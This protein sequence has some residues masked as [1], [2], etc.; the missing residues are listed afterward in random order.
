[1]FKWK[2]LLIL[3]VLFFM[4]V[5]CQNGEENAELDHSENYNENETQPVRF[6]S[7]HEGMQRNTGPYSQYMRQEQFPRTKKTEYDT[8]DRV[9]DPYMNEEAVYIRNQLIKRNEIVNAHV[10]ST[11]DRIVVVVMLEPHFNH[12]SKP[13][14]KDIEE[15]VNDLVPT[16]EKDIVVY[17]DNTE[18]D[19]RKN[20][21]ARMNNR[22]R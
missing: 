12:E 8:G 18:W 17:T 4:L 11:E 9:T 22:P 16:I 19:K 1:M 2:P 3:G 10:S 20:D 7:R 13:T 6:D 5:G 15:F 14:E 21:N